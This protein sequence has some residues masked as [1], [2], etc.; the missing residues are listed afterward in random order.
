[1]TREVSD[2]K[3]IRINNRL[4]AR[5]ILWFSSGILQIKLGRA[6]I[7]PVALLR[8]VNGYLFRRQKRAL[9]CLHR[10]KKSNVSSTESTKNIEKFPRIKQ[11]REW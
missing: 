7:V 9:K 8:A 3:K 2:A 5:P 11:A 1:M 4:I 10:T 6:R